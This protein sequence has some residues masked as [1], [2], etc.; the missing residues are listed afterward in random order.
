MERIELKIEGMSCGHCVHAVGQALK[1]LEGV[2]VERV[3]IGS[4][5][6]AYDP[7]VVKPEAIEAAVVEEGY[8][9]RSIGA[10]A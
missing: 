2:Q 3:E 6:V 4:A 8:E 9:V 1:G 5:V 7:A 10:V